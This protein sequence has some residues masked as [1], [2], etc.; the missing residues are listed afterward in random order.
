MAQQATFATVV[1][2][3]NRLD[4]LLQRVE[5][6]LPPSLRELQEHLLQIKRTCLMA[7]RKGA[8][9]ATEDLKP[10]TL[11]RFLQ[12]LY[13]FLAPDPRIVERLG[14]HKIQLVLS[15]DAEEQSFDP[16]YDFQDAWAA[17][18]IFHRRPE[19]F[20]DVGSRLI[21]LDDHLSPGSLYRRRRAA[22]AGGDAPVD[23]SSWRSPKPPL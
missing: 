3:V 12:D 8:I 4:T 9:E 18:I 11:V 22:H 16:I 19:F 21:F 5:G 10:E 1:Q 23:L 7:Q 2:E 20:V 6:P 13:R 15:F 17:Q 14:F